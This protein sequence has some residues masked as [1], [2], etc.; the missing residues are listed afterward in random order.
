MQKTPIERVFEL[1]DGPS[2]VARHFLGS[3][4]KPLT[5]WAVSKWRKRVPVERV[6][7]L[8]ELTGGQ[9]TRYELRPDVYGQGPKERAAA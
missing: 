6:L 3:N 2:A 9:V 1:L 8:E 5:P 4:G 7:K